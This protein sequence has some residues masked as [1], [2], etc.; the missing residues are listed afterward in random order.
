[1]QTTTWTRQ[2]V[3]GYLSILILFTGYL[4]GNQRIS[5]NIKTIHVFLVTLAQEETIVKNRRNFPDHS[6]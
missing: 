5:D 3:T 1:V 4:T 2:V 6:E